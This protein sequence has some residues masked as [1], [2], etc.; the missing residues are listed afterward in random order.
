VTIAKRPSFRARDARTDARDLPDGASKAPAAHWHDGQITADFSSQ[1]TKTR[2]FSGQN[3]RICKKPAKKPRKTVQKA[4]DRLWAVYDHDGRIRG[5]TMATQL[6]K[7]QL[8]E[9]LATATEL[10]KRDVK[11]VM[12]SLTDVGHKELKKSGVFL[13]PGFAK[14]VVVKK[15][16]TK[17]RKGTNPFT[18]EEMMFK[19]KPARKIVR[20]RPVKA[21][22]DAV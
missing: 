1:C 12:D 6:S 19:A 22:K 13:L 16:A 2:I 17:A 4:L 14:F 11:N 21:A 9:K 5:D 20:A 15:P 3:P 7:S 18:G 10:S 8:V